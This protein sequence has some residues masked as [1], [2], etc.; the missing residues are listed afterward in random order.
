LN[1]FVSAGQNYAG[2]EIGRVAGFPIRSLKNKN[3]LN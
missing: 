2:K 3:I 1:A